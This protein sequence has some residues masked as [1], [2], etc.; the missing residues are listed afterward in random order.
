[1]NRILVVEDELEIAQVLEM[2]LRHAEFMTERAST[3]MRALELY[4]AFNPHLVLLDI[5]IPAPDGL[6]VLRQIRA[7]GTTPVILVTAR[8]DDIDRLLG[9]ELGA[10]DYVVKPF[11]PREVVARV[12]AVLR[13]SYMATSETRVYRVGDLEL[14]QQTMIV[15][16][17][18]K[19]LD[20]TLAEYR[21]LEALM[22]TKGRPFSRS[23]L[24]EI[25]RPGSDMLERSV[26]THLKNLRR[27]LE[28][29]GLGRYLETVRGIGYRFWDEP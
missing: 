28:T 24:A 20:L 3:G 6:E 11:W 21:V 12:K 14:D 15:R 27:K 10:D 4:A 13:R 16:S 29:I 18:E 23:E 26:D 22:R 2:Y 1:M 8:V 9:L 5:Q 17:G 19:R 25:M 7:R